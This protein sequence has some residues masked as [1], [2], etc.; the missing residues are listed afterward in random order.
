MFT[1]V[2]KA[3]KLPPRQA[4]SVATSSQPAQRSFLG[5]DLYGLLVLLLL[6]SWPTAAIAGD[7]SY[8]LNPGDEL[9]ISVWKE[10]DLQREVLVLPDGTVGFPLAGQVQAEGLTPDGLEAAIAERLRSYVPDALVTVSVLKAAGNKIYV[11][12][13]VNKP[14]EY[15]PSRPLTVMQALSLA[16]GLTAFASESRIIVL[17]KV[18]EEEV[19]LPV[20][21]DDLQRG[22]RLDQNHELVSGDSIVVPPRSLF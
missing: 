3:R 18:G 16:G 9:L 19:A 14:G 11:L 21:Y 6:A 15:Q 17:R 7:D 1:A 13:E 5:G 8:R 20:P 2:S 22:E 4:L 12:G 10:Q